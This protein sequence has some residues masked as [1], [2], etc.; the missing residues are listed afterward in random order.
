M[1]PVRAA[2]TDPL[3]LEGRAALWPDAI[4]V[5][6]DTSPNCTLQ[7][8]LPVAPYEVELVSLVRVGDGSRNSY[9]TGEHDTLWISSTH[10]TRLLVFG[11]RGG[12]LTAHC[13]GKLVL[14]AKHIPGRPE[15]PQFTCEAVEVLTTTDS[16]RLEID[17]PLRPDGFSYLTPKS[18]QA[19][20]QIALA[21]LTDGG[22]LKADWTGTASSIK[23]QS[24]Q[25]DGDTPV[26][27]H[28]RELVPSWLEAN[29]DIMVAIAALLVCIMTLL[30]FISDV[31]K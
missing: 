17:S 24:A 22:G 29:R 5:A 4:R 28:G 7:L 26:I 23:V 3:W 9:I 31:W 12:R 2:T 18:I 16:V 20:G 15:H 13:R 25:P 30:R 6:G 10:P 19:C 8:Q 1:N 14:I 27:R 21:V 11:H